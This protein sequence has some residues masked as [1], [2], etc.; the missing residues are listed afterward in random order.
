MLAERLPVIASL[1]TVEH[2]E[3]AHIGAGEQLALAVEIK[4]PHVPPTLAK[5]S[6]RLV[7]G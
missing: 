5:S 2:R 6:N 1:N 4:A 3:P 7:V